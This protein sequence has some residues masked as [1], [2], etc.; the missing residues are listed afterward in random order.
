MKTPPAR[1]QVPGGGCGG[2]VKCLRGSRLVQ[3]YRIRLTQRRFQ[4]SFVHSLRRAD[5]SGQ[6]HRDMVPGVEIVV[7][8][9]GSRIGMGLPFREL[10]R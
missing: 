9:L 1:I 10:N 6:A 7:D 2:F 8:A 4:G 5:L 3:E